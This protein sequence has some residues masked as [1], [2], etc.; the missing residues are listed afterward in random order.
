[1]PHGSRPLEAMALSN[2]MNPS[3]RRGEQEEEEASA[4]AAGGDEPPAAAAAS[5]SQR[6]SSSKKSLESL[7]ADLL[8]AMG[9][10]IAAASHVTPVLSSLYSLA[11]L[12][13]V[14]PIPAP[15][16][17]NMEAGAS[18]SHTQ[19]DVVKEVSTLHGSWCFF[20][21]PSVSLSTIVSH[22]HLV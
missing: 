4:A 1:L 10:T 6:A 11:S 8:I 17:D 19:L 20:Q 13:W 16:E 3:P 9:A 2:P 22:I 15:K 7:L 12:L 21:A 5:S 14:I 18:S